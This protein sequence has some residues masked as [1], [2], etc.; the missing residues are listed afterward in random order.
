MAVVIIVCVTAANDLMSERQFQKLYS[1]LEQ[2][3]VEVTRDDQIM[4]ISID[5]LLVGDIFH[6]NVGEVFPVDGVLVEGHC[7]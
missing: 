1:Q 5:D 6:F 2:R 7:I 3:D 4:V